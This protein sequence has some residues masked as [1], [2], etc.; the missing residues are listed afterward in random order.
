VT[1]K[2][3]VDSCMTTLSSL[4]L[5][6]INKTDDKVARGTSYWSFMD[7]GAASVTALRAASATFAST[8][9][10]L[11]ASMAWLVANA[12]PLLTLS[13]GETLCSIWPTVPPGST[14]TCERSTRVPSLME[15]PK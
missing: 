1:R 5:E 6:S 13:C 4:G 2:V 9:S 8:Q 7:M 3:S 14:I 11:V 12:R 10:L 15:L